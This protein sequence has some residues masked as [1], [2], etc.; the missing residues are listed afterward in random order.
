MVYGFGRDISNAVEYAL[1]NGDLLQ[2]TFV[3][4]LT[5]S[6]SKKKGSGANEHKSSRTSRGSWRNRA[7][8]LKRILNKNRE[9]CYFDS[10]VYIGREVISRENE[11][12]IVLDWGGLVCLFDC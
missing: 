12:I 5:T 4:F 2:G 3:L 9:L 10:N 1:Y 6:S 8:A 7:T 11:F